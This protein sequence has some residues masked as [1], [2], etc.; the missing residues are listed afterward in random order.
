MVVVVTLVTGM[1]ALLLW[2]CC[3]GVHMER[4]RMENKITAGPGAQLDQEPRSSEAARCSG[5]L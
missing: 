1:L 5:S 3:V 4:K 2:G